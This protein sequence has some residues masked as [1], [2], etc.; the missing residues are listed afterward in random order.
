MAS[1]VLF[2]IFLVI[3]QSESAKIKLGEG[4]VEDDSHNIGSSCVAENDWCYH[5]EE[6]CDGF[7][8]DFPP[9]REEFQPVSKE[10]FQA[11]NGDCLQAGVCRSVREGLCA[12]KW[13]HCDILP[14]CNG[15][16]CTC[17]GDWV[18]ECSCW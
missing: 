6:C 17:A 7:A 14:C 1:E 11:T 8:C 2:F 10:A 18:V 5:D 3:S 12:L 4:A 16:P 13:E 15:R 9:D